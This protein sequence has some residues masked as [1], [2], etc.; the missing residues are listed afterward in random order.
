MIYRL[1]LPSMN[2]PVPKAMV[3]E[4]CRHEGEL[5]I[6]GDEICQ[7][8]VEELVCRRQ[9]YYVDDFASIL[10]GDGATLRAWDWTRTDVEYHVMLVSSDRAWLR[11][12]CSPATSCAV[13]GDLLAL[14]TS[15]PDE[16]IT[17]QPAPFSSQPLFRAVPN[18]IDAAALDR[19]PLAADSEVPRDLA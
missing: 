1:T 4:W 11:K 8:A 5:V 14:F 12:I 13:A 6:Y 16:P 18:V 10:R 19:V 3:V 17:G 9:D 2:P 15:S 7:L